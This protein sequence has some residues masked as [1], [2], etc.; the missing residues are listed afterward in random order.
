MKADDLA[1]SK[2]VF[3]VERS[4]SRHGYSDSSLYVASVEV[5]DNHV[6]FV[7][8]DSEYCFTAHQCTE[9]ARNLSRMLLTYSDLGI[10]QGSAESVMRLEAHASWCRLIEAQTVSSKRDLLLACE[11]ES[12]GFEFCASGSFR[13]PE[14]Q[15]S[16]PDYYT[17][18]IALDDEL[19][20]PCLGIE[21]RTFSFDFEEAYWLVKQLWIAGYL[22][23]Q[24]EEPI[25]T[26]VHVSWINDKGQLVWL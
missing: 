25:N 22:V 11:S 16:E 5:V 13:R 26:K 14:S 19:G 20:L 4:M 23:A 9:V 7:I 18:T 10:C 8:D 21:D 24:T 15:S 12:K 6:S 1:A 3:M 2:V 17:L